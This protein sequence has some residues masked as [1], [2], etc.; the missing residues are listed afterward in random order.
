LLVFVV[1]VFDLINKEHNHVKQTEVHHDNLAAT[2]PEITAAGN[3]AG[4]TT[5]HISHTIV[6]PIKAARVNNRMP[7]IAI[8][9]PVKKLFIYIKY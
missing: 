6:P 5:G 7:T 9:N 4:I 3:T 8:P 1:V 2:V